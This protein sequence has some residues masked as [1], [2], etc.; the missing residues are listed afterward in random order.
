MT[1]PTVADLMHPEPFTVSVHNS[2]T[3]V[4]TLMLNGSFHHVPL[5]DGKRLVGI[6]SASDL[7]EALSDLPPELIETGVILDEKHSLVDLAQ[8]EVVTVSPEDPLE[9]A[10]SRMR[11]GGFHALPVVRDG[12]LVGILT[13]TDILRARLQDELEEPEGASELWP[14]RIRQRILADHAAIRIMIDQIAAMLHGEGDGIRTATL[15]ARRCS[16]LLLFLVEHMARE[17]QLVIPALKE[18]DAWGD[19][20]TA[21]LREHHKSQRSELLEVL[22]HIHQP[23]A[24]VEEIEAALVALIEDLRADMEQEERGLL[25]PN[26]LKDDPISVDTGGV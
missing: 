14:S 4:Y 1:A 15:L 11:D 3:D 2:L 5:V 21:Q 20:R 26:V 24:R 12:E 9:L 25:S 7:V 19:V 22:E 13:S 18:A 10:V 17:E 8:R 23:A 16:D 6:I